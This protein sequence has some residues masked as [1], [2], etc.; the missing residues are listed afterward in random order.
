MILL[1]LFT[2]GGKVVNTVLFIITK[3]IVWYVIGMLVGYFFWPWKGRDGDMII[4]LED[5]TKD[6]YTLSLNMPLVRLQ[7]KK[8]ISIRVR[9]KDNQPMKIRTK[10]KA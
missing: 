8:Y 9:T 1:F 10:N 2:K 7:T 6:V 5:P 4:D 3:S